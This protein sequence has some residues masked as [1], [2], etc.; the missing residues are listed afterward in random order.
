MDCSMNLHNLTFLLVGQNPIKN[1]VTNTKGQV[2]YTWP[3]SH[4]WTSIY[5]SLVWTFAGCNHAT[6]T[7]KLQENHYS[8]WYMPL[9]YNKWIW[10]LLKHM[11]QLTTGQ[12]L[13]SYSLPE[14]LSVKVRFQDS[15]LFTR[16]LSPALKASGGITGAGQLQWYEG[17]LEICSLLK[18]VCYRLEWI[19]FNERNAYA[20]VEHTKWHQ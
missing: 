8:L 16:S 10:K 14:L 6:L 17:K 19:S 2:L 5:S 18:T 4:I 9:G 15:P 1:E 13:F 3:D 11:W 12:W 20:V 7:T